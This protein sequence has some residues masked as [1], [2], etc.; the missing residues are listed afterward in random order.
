MRTIDSAAFL[1]QFALSLIAGLA[2]AQTPPA[3]LVVPSNATM[4]VGDTR[5]FR[6]VG[7]DGRKQQN[8]RWTV[9][10]AHA[11]TLTTAGDEATVQA[12]EPS[13]TV[14]LTAVAGGDSAEA[15][16]EIQS[17]PAMAPGTKIWSV[18][19]LPGCKTAKMSQAVPTAN[20]PDLYVEEA[21]PDGTVIRAMTADG[22]EIWRRSLGDHATPSALN[23]KT[24]EETRPVDRLNLNAHSVCDGVSPGMTKDAVAKLAQDR[25]LRLE[26]KQEASDSWLYE[27]SGFSCKILFDQAGTVV[28]K[29]KTILTD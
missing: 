28:K 27:E 9:S 11:A 5:T 10:P 12:T 8:V 2:L 15:S 6:A 21:C 25:G 7:K 17:G 1:A 16:I 29:K 4:L 20:G 18:S 26:E 23:L 19:N 3:L 22:R 14:V 24:K 13:A